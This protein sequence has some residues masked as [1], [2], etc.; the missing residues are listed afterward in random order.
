MIFNNSIKELEKNLVIDAGTLTNKG[1]YFYV[2]IK[3]GAPVEIYAVPLIGDKRHIRIVETYVNDK[4]CYITPTEDGKYDLIPTIADRGNEM[5]KIEKIQQI[6]GAYCRVARLDPVVAYARIPTCDHID[7]EIH[8]QKEFF[9]AYAEKSGYRLIELYADVGASGMDDTRPEY[10]RMLTDAEE[11]RFEYIFVK[12]VAKFGRDYRKVKR[13][14]Q[15]LLNCG[16]GVF[17]LNENIC[18]LEKEWRS[19]IFSIPGLSN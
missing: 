15:Q 7:E 6:I 3:D 12:S 14:T 2:A 10:C 19:N 4:E 18:S 16:V 17:F 13:T 11:G 8:K 1:N 9:T 5:P